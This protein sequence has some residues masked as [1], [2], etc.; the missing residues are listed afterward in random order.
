MC[1]YINEVGILLP[2]A[3]LASS[4]CFLLMLGVFC[5]KYADKIVSF[6]SVVVI[7]IALYL[8]KNI[9]IATAFNQMFINNILIQNLKLLLLASSLLY[10][11]FLYDRQKFFFSSMLKTYEFP[12]ILLLA[13]T[14]MMLMLSANNFLSFYV[15]LELQSFALYVL[16]AFERESIKSSEAGLK[17]FILGSFASGLLLFGISMIYG[18]NGSLD[19]NALSVELSNHSN[20]QL[21]ISIGLIMIMVG[22]FFKSSAAPFHMWAPD[23]YQGSPTIVTALLATVA[24]IAI[25]GFLLRFSIEILSGWKEGLQPIFI[26]VTCAS[27]LIGSIAGLKQ[28]NIKRLLAYSSISHIGY[29]LLA[30]STF[31]LNDSVLNYLLIYTVM[32]MGVFVSIMVIRVNKQQISNIADLSGLAK[33][34]PIIA[35]SLSVFL[36][37]L[38]GIPPFAGFFAKFYI[39]KS[40]VAYGLYV[41]VFISII[42]SVISAFYYLRL[43]KTIYFDDS[44]GLFTLDMTMLTKLGILVLVLFNL[45]YIISPYNY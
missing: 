38:A 35:F 14:G 26:L 1:N 12:V 3:F 41:P 34:N 17:Y 7:L 20:N 45:F 37:S 25:L 30:I 44:Q 15:S 19:F 10:S 33:N 2:E 24:K 9:H 11:I 29:I 23:V 22:L 4:A 13:L 21:T 39:F 8:V 27:V 5:K 31:S 40:A 43:V 18:F 6:L 36:F 16:A 28:N 42:A 32:T